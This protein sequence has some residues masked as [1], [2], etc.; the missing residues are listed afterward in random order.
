LR[1][2]EVEKVFVQVI[3]DLKE[4]LVLDSVGK[5]KDPPGFC[6]RILKSLT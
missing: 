4:I 6:I 1:I 2:A 3:I 5:L